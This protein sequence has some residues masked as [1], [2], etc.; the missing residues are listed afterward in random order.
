MANSDSRRKK[1]GSAEIYEGAIIPPPKVLT[2]Y[3]DRE[4]TIDRKEKARQKGIAASRNSKGLARQ[5]LLKV[6]LMKKITNMN[7]KKRRNFCNLTRI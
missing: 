6:I 5:K 7:K 2:V 3:Q 4:E 1:F